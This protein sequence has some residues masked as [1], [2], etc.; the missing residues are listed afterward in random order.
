MPS[1]ARRATVHLGLGANLGDRLAALRSAVEELA[2]L[3]RIAARSSVWET[4]PVG[5]SGT[6]FLNGAVALE[7]EREPEALLDALLAIERRHGRVRPAASD[8]PKLPRPLDLDLL[9]WGERIVDTPRLTV[10]H[11]RLAERSF[12]LAP[13]AEIA[14]GAIHPL[15][16]C[17]IQQLYQRLERPTPVR[18]L[19]VFL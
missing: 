5:V 10:P 16:H 18:R 14:A 3:G 17:S 11:P 4:D 15:L 2:A 12:V 6:A 1:G 7:T 8:A 13:L 9:L 19:D